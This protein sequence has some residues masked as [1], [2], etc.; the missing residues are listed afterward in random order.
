MCKELFAKARY[1]FP[2]ASKNRLDAIVYRQ[3]MEIN[4][5]KEE[6]DDP[7]LTLKPDCTMS[8]YSKPAAVVKQKQK[9]FKGQPYGKKTPSSR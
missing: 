6:K 2:D 4:H 7:E 8:A 5:G 9:Y 3:I 1:E